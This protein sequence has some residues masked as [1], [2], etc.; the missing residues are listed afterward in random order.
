M[1]DNEPMESDFFDFAQAFGDLKQMLSK[2]SDTISELSEDMKKKKKEEY[3][4]PH[5]SPYPKKKN[6]K[7]SEG[8]DDDEEEDKEKE[9][10]KKK[11]EEFEAKEKEQAL[12]QF[13]EA[14]GNEELKKELS[15]FSV[16]QIKKL[17]ELTR[18]KTISFGK[19]LKGPESGKDF[20]KEIKELE[21]KEKDFKAAGLMKSA[22]EVH[23]RLSKLKGD[24]D[25][26]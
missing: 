14:Q 13:A 6:K 24:E 1:V 26:E 8:D 10:M 20:S 22:E 21:Q 9:E 23:A 15:D 17:Q 5:P 4:Y 3:P 7:M 18:A 12:A 11:I 2:I 25:G 19:T 16:D